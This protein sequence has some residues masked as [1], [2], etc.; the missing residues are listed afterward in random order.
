[1]NYVESENASPQY[2]VRMART[3]SDVRQAQALRYRVFVQELGANGPLIDHNARL[4]KDDFDKHSEQLLLLDMARSD[5]DRV[6]GVYRLMDNNSASIAGQF[7][8][9]REFDLRPLIKSGRSL[10]ELG[11]SCLHVD[12]RGGAG[13]MH[14][15]QGLAKIVRDR[16][17]DVLFGVASFHGTDL[18][19]LAPSLSLLHCDYLAPRDICVR[20]NTYEALY[21]GT[22]WDRV[23]AMKQVPA[24]MKAY[25]RLGGFVGDGAYVDHEFNTTDVCV[26]LDLARMNQHQAAIYGI[27]DD[28]EV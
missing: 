22:V 19:T 27:R 11:R 6:V 2:T 4:E 17:I 8:S 16:Q 26:I 21:R 13:M 28:L 9:Q 25:L 7:Y 12:Y 5:G 1:M 3:V 23:A 20:S 15:W 18:D 10:L 14:L 24:L